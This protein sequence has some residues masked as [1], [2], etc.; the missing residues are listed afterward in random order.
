MVTLKARSSAASF[1]AS[2][3]STAAGE[4][5]SVHTSNRS[6]TTYQ[7]KLWHGCNNGL[8]CFLSSSNGW[9]WPKHISKYW[10]M[11]GRPKKVS[12]LFLK[13]MKCLLLVPNIVTRYLLTTFEALPSVLEEFG[14]TSLYLW[15]G[16]TLLAI[17][18]V[19]AGNS[20]QPIQLSVRRMIY[21]TRFVSVSPWR[22]TRE[23]D[24]DRKKKWL[25]A[26]KLPCLAFR[27]QK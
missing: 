5:Q 25:D 16:N 3:R 19:V 17:L 15:S 24:G 26:N 23:E 6:S 13:R 12:F 11:P 18:C 27:D 22:Q 7:D 4:I 14:F 10:I 21:E 8:D 20:S 1:L 9:L 2:A